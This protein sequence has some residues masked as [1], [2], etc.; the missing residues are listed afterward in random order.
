MSTM[1]EQQRL[2]FWSQTHITT[3]L[4]FGRKVPHSFP[5][6]VDL[7]YPRIST[8]Q[9]TKHLLV[10]GASVIRGA[11]RVHFPCAKRV[12][13]DCSIA[14]SNRCYSY[15]NHKNY[16]A[17]P[18][19]FWHGPMDINNWKVS[20][21]YQVYFKETRAIQFSAHCYSEISLLSAPWLLLKVLLKFHQVPSHA[22]FIF[23]H[24]CKMW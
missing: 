23:P 13:I 14:Q 7:S 12:W 21:S 24:N 3:A 8:L 20:W 2:F 11:A 18:N 5:S 22:Q 16:L 6:Q 1:F 4:T 10:P 15:P 9:I 19:S 17:T